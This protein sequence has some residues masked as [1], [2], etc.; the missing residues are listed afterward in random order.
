MAIKTQWTGVDPRAEVARSHL[1]ESN[2]TIRCPKN[3]KTGNNQEMRNN[4][5][6]VRL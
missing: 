6:S 1:I 4:R 3:V 2:K 5:K